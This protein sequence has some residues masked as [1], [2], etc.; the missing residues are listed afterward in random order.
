MELNNN[1]LPTMPSITPAMMR[2]EAT[3]VYSKNAAPSRQARVDPSPSE[4]C[5][6]PK[7]DWLQV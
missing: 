6:E 5:K 4:P 1:T 2:Q 7:N 3:F